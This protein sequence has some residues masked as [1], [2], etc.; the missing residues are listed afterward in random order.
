MTDFKKRR[1]QGKDLV[2][3]GL[4][5]AGIVLLALLAFASVRGAWDMYGKFADAAHARRDAEAQLASLQAHYATVKGTVEDLQ[6]ERG[7]EAEVR[8]RYGLSRPGE[9]QIDIVRHAST[10]PEAAPKSDTLFERLW[11]VLFV[12]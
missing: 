8:E 7:L 11:D 12:W 10:T 9:G 3:V 4:G 1:S 6:S 2:R 5:C